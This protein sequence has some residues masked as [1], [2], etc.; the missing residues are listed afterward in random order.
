[1]YIRD[2]IFNESIYLFNSIVWKSHRHF[3]TTPVSN[4]TSHR[5]P[6]HP[7]ALSAPWPPLPFSLDLETMKH[8]GLQQLSN[9][10]ILEKLV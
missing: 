1:M 9:D 7:F 6:Q 8:V 5:E 4:R 2:H 10:E 3:T